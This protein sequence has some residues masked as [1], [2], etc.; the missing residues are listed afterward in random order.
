MSHSN[1]DS[2]HTDWLILAY[3]LPGKPSAKRVY[4]WRKL[5]R[6]RAERFAGTVWVLPATA[7]NR[8]EFQWLSAE[9]SELGGTAFLWE[10]RSLIPGQNEDLQEAFVVSIESEYREIVESLRANTPSLTSLIRHYRAV[11]ARDWFGSPL[12]ETARKSLAARRNS[13]GRIQ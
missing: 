11:T 13:T 2:N 7:R 6:L 8:E 3:K 5:K 10:S 4:V 12:R 1:T 9:I